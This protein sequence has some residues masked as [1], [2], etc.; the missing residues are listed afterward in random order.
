M[1]CEPLAGWREVSVSDHRGM[2]DFADVIK[3]LV[4]DLYPDAERIVLVTDNLNT[5]SP[6]SLYEVFEPAEAKRLAD[7]LEIHYSLS[8]GVGSTWPRSS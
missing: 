5:H 1:L 3:H 4:D 6:G 2:V 8:T 7:K